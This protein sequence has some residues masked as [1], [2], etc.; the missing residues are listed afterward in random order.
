MTRPITELDF[1]QI[2]AELVEF[3]KNN[4]TFSDYNFQGS[5]LNC[6]MDILAFNTHTNAYYANMAHNEGFLDTAQK[7]SSVVSHSKPFGYVPKSMTCS[8][9]Y[10][11]ISVSGLT[12]TTSLT[13]PRGTSFTAK[14]DNGSYQFIVADT[15]SANV[16]GSNKVFDSVKLVN[17]KN[18]QNYFTVNTLTNIRSFFTIPN[19]NIDIST[20]KVFVRETLSSVERTEYF[21]A[22]NTYELTPTSNVYFIQESHDGFYQIYF[23]DDVLGIQPVN[24]NIIDI[25]YIVTDDINNADGCKLFSLNGTIG[26]ATGVSIVTTQQSFGGANRE[27]I[28]SIRYNGIKS[29]SARGRS[30]NIYD[31]EL[32]LKRE[33]GFIKSVSVW[34]GE[35]NVPPVYGKVFFSIQP[36]SG[37]TLSDAVKKDIITP[38]IRKNSVVT[39]IPHFVDPTYTNLEITTRIRFN[40][41]KTTSSQIGVESAI[42]TAISEYISSISSFNQDYLESTLLNTIT[43]LDVGIVSVSVSKRVGFKMSPIIGILSSH[44]RTINNPIKAGTI[45]STKFSTYAD[46]IK[47]VTIREIP[48]SSTISVNSD[49]TSSTI[50]RLGMYDQD[51]VLISDIGTVNLYT[52]DFNIS[53]NLYSYISDTRFIS[54]SC[55]LEEDDIIV[56]RNQILNLDANNEDSY[57]GLLDNNKVITE[58]YVK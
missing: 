36:V 3:I 28:D 29:N 16:V 30:I 56:R 9:A 8:T 32:Q 27:A 33:F 7:R 26:N 10:V 19:K 18:I 53:Y 45:K 15:V 31:Y 41:Q 58:L 17:G 44:T 14:N 22:T 49:G 40:P 5:A 34:G 24:G 46:G 52:G 13:I 2:K 57:I 21:V 4:P 42:K 35:N 39:V 1:D 48:N 51:D 25:D 12:D 54:L 38:A 50:V 11:N 6:I 20:L 23:G 47:T 55:E 37:F 43:N